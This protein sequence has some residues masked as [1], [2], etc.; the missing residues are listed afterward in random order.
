MFRIDRQKWLEAVK[1]VEARREASPGLVAQAKAGLITW[2]QFQDSGARSYDEAF[3]EELTKLYS[4]RAQAHDHLHRRRAR[5]T[6]SQ[7]LKLA[8]PGAATMPF[9]E[10]GG[11]LVFDLTA[12][13]Q[14]L[15]VG[16]AY[17]E[18]E[19][20][21]ELPVLTVTEMVPATVR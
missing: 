3:Q 17:K 8:I 4:I 20:P 11:T 5:L 15:Y 6:Y 10:A 2:K 1:A 16:D 12:E 9:I 21:E 18:F 7:A 19:R 13:Q 14:A